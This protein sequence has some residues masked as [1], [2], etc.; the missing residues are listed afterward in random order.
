MR[1]QTMTRKVMRYATRSPVARG[2]A[3]AALAAAAAACGGAERPI[4]P[5]DDD[6]DEE[7][8]PASIELRVSPQRFWYHR[9]QT[10][11]LAATV[12][13]GEG[14]ILGDADIAWAVEPA[15]AA[16]AT[17][18]HAEIPGTEEFALHLEGAIRFTAC[19]IGD[20]GAAGALCDS[21]ALRVDDGSPSLE[22]SEPQP[23]AELDDPNGIVVRG[24]V[25]DASDA[26]VYVLG[27]H[28]EV[29]ELGQFEETLIARPGV[30]HIDV[31][32]SDG[33]TPNAVVELDVLWA[34]AY[35]AANASGDD[36]LILP[37][38][39]ALSLGQRLFDGGGAFEDFEVNDLAGLIGLIASNLPV[40]ELIPSPVIDEPTFRLEIPDASLGEAQVTIGVTS[41]GLDLFLRFPQLTLT[42][43]GFI[44]IDETYLDLDGQVRASV[45]AAV[46]IEVR[47]GGGEPVSIEVTDPWVAVES[48]QGEFVS[49][50]TGA[51]FRLA[52]SLFRSMI[53]EQLEGAVAAIVQDTLPSLLGEALAAL[54]GLL[55]EQE[56]ELDLDMLP[57]PISLSI[58]GE[59]GP[60]V[61]TQATEIAA[62]LETRLGVQSD[63]LHPGT[64]GVALFHPELEPPRFV[65]D[66]ELQVGVRLSLINGV[67][68]ALWSAGLLE[69]DLHALLPDSIASLIQGGWVS[70]R[71]PPIVRAPRLGEP[72]AV[73]IAL[74]QVELE[75]DLGPDGTARFGASLEASV[76]LAVDGQQVGIEVPGGPRLRVW[77]IEPAPGTVF[78]AELVEATLK[79]QFDSL[80]GELLG[81]LALE[82]PSLPVGDYLADLAPDL[83][84][85]T[86]QVAIDDALRVRGDFLMLGAG[87]RGGLESLAAPLFARR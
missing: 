14:R 85:L 7:V 24:S 49:P 29:D 35:L 68:H 83:A 5:I 1:V 25:V 17:G 3:F 39:L 62:A 28:V 11:R 77:T 60:F 75:L 82:L 4:G 50:E 36:P 33:L 87:L 72:G 9:D 34:P 63:I 57:A 42:T 10:V 51:I 78:T 69:I 66:G 79:D 2:L 44:Q 52:E 41:S 12:E 22:V 13:D 45:A 48:A 71:L 32:A 16:T 18:D 64:R 46:L 54:D 81:P 43:E 40:G 27:Q 76:D 19:V 65:R 59:L 61:A 67:L 20:D 47:G 38:G 23:G 86:L 15:G 21:V 84:E 80:M 37:E 74:G 56:L 70:G 55:G 58:A 53:E 6:E 26:R 30:N 31:V 8:R 73:V